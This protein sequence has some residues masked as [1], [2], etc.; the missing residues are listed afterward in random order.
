M[1]Q[2]WMRSSSWVRNSPSGKPC[3]LRCF[4]KCALRAC[5]V[6][7]AG[8]WAPEISL[9]PTIFAPKRA[10]ACAAKL[11]TFPNPCTMTRLWGGSFRGSAA[12]LS[13]NAAP[14]PAASFRPRE[15]PTVTGLP[16]TTLGTAR[17]ACSEKVSK[18]HAMFC[19]LVPMSGAGTPVLGPMKGSS[20]SLKR[21]V[22]DSS[23]RA[24]MASGSHAMPHVAPTKGR[25]NRAHFKLIHMAS[26]ATSPRS[27]CRL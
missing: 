14:R 6:N 15:P 16:V 5:R 12:R 11:P 9:T 8:W 25:S 7:P 10:M 21:R 26:A 18:I 22:R 24:L 13:R 3:R 1:S 27:T 19:S 17:A 2:G 20:S 4:S 23:S